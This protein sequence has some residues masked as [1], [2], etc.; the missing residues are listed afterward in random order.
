MNNTLIII[1]AYNE[2][3]TIGKLLSSILEKGYGKFSDI[4]VINDCSKDHTEREVC[5]YE[6]SV[7][8]IN[9]IFNMGY[10]AALK[11]GYAYATKNGYQYVIQLDGD[12]QHGV[13][14]I[15][16]LYDEIRSKEAPNIIIGSRFV[17]GSISFK[18][19]KLKKIAIYFFRYLIKIFTKCSITDPTS[20][21][22]ALDREA[23]SYYSEFMNF[24]PRYPDANMIIKMILLGYKIE[25]I[26]SMMYERT[27]GE[28]I[29]SGLK[30]I[31]YMLLM[32][33]STITVIL[34]YKFLK[35][36]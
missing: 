1:P 32:M 8:L 18:I 17:N 34:E 26:P 29:H 25:E 28:S 31:G 3:F 16:K 23:F 14:N 30:P 35:A 6:K 13:E 4:L 27:T 2:E 20:G 22:Q 5:Q 19:S 11:T 12:G 24:D 7:I 36:K 9:H 33:L 10:G 21:L 15:R